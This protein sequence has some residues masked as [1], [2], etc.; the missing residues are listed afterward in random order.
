M[1]RFNLEK[2]VNMILNNEKLYFYYISLSVEFIS[3]SKYKNELNDMF[4]ESESQ[5]ETLLELENNTESIEQT[6]NII[7]NYLF[8]KITHINFQIVGKLLFEELRQQYYNNPASLKELTHRLYL[9]W[10]LLPSEISSEEPFI[11]LNSI[12]DS[13]EWGDEEQV[14]ENIKYLFDYYN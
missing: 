4:L 2:S 7:T 3:F 1:E 11:K 13:W 6:I 12:D 14:V 5:N 10:M 9:I 8:D